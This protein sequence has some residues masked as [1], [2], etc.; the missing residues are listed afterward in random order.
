MSPGKNKND[1]L[2]KDL[3]VLGK[4]TLSIKDFYKLDTLPVKKKTALFSR[5]FNS[6]LAKGLTYMR[7]ITGP[8][9]HVVEVRDNVTGEIRKMRM[10]GSNNYLGMANN[11]AVRGRIEKYIKEYGVGLGGPPMLNGRTSIHRKLEKELSELK[12]CQDTMIFSSGF[13]ANLGWIN[14]LVGKNDLLIM[15]ELCHAS[16]IEAS[17]RIRGSFCFFSHNDIQSLENQLKKARKEEAVNIFVVVEGV[18]SMD[19]DL[20]PLRKI[21]ELAKNHRAFLAVDDAH[22]TGVV[23]ENGKGAAE[24]F[25]LEGKIDLVMGT[26]SKVFAST[27]G[28]VSGDK[29]LIDYLRFFAK[30]YFFSASPSPLH[31]ASVLAAL[32][33][34]VEQP[35]L[36]RK[37]HENVDYLVAGLNDLGL[38]IQTASSIVPVY[39]PAGVNIRKLSREFDVAGFFLNMVE[40]PAVPLDKQRFRISVMATHTKEDL[41][42]L[43]A[44]MDKIGRKAGLIGKNRRKRK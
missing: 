15:D 30:T 23:G 1:D 19:G 42:D 39:V 36:I 6:E 14:A 5:Y 11:P 3:G 28:F 2:W 8:M 9:D 43:I 13:S 41:D 22:G 21:Y 27:G 4:K 17:K 35:Q 31:I 40:F 32:E 12:S 26:F 7:E 34:I 16:I 38:N 44:S 29:E 18:Y 10:F 25:G 33:V 37:L 24:L 20:P